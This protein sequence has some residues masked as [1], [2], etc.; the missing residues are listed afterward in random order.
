MR[1]GKV[2]VVTDALSPGFFFP[3]WYNYYGCHFGEKNLHVATLS[4]KAHEFDGFALGSV[5]EISESYDDNYRLRSITDLVSKLLLDNDFVIRVDCDEFLVAKPEAYRNIRDYIDGLEI[6]YVTSRGFEIFQHDDDGPLD[7]NEKILLKQ[8]KYALAA[9]ALNKPSITSV[10][11]RWNRGFHHCNHGPLF[12]QVFLFHLKRADLQW[13]LDWNRLVAPQIVTDEG[14]RAYY[15]TPEQQLRQYHKSWS[16]KRTEV[17]E[18]VLY[19]AAFNDEFLNLVI[20]NERS[21][22]FN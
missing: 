19:R 2:A 9:T 8:R 14:I 20:Y 11:L 5:T 21:G 22:T 18:N 12:D 1:T 16:Q 3:L 4:G 10:P 17:G 13:Q 15:E 7:V 6:P